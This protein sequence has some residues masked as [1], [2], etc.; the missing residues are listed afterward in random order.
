MSPH[1][2]I[3]H[4]SHD[5]PIDSRVLKKD[6]NFEANLQCND[7]GPVL[8]DQA[9]ENREMM[10]NMAVELQLLREKLTRYNVAN[11]NLVHNV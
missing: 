8:S 9:G 7:D 4:C 6:E 3:A 10:M 1:P 2:H 11:G 5:V